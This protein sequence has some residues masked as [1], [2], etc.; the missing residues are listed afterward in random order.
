MIV[1]AAAFGFSDIVMMKYIA[2]GMIFALFIDATIVRMLLVPA[3]MHLLRE[4]NWWAPKFIHKA[5]E[6]MGHGSEPAMA[7]A[8]VATTV[9]AANFESQP[10]PVAHELG[11]E[12]FYDSY[13]DHQ[14][15]EEDHVA[16]EDYD[17]PG[18]SGRTIDEDESLVPFNVL[19][20]RLAQER[21]SINR[22]P[23][24]RRLPRSKDDNA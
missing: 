4:D 6:K 12:E 22:A 24:H 14:Q 7:T 10:E 15:W 5:Y 13:N 17:G 3:V 20:E 8:P 16:E 18:R 19:M 21:R 2:F 11:E 9:G 1:V 23:E